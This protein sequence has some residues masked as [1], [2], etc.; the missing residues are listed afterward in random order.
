VATGK[1]KRICIFCGRL[2]LTNEHVIPQWVSKVVARPRPKQSRQ[3]TVFSGPGEGRLL[4][5]KSNSWQSDILGTMAKQVCSTCNSGWMSQLESA[6]Q[7]LVTPML[8]GIATELTPDAQ[9]VLARWAFKTSSMVQYMRSPVVPVPSERL[10]WL[11]K[12]AEPPTKAWVALGKYNGGT[13]ASWC[14]HKGILWRGEG[15]EPK[16]ARGQLVTLS[17]GQLVIQSVAWQGDLDLSVKLSE[18]QRRYLL[19]IWPRTA[20]IILKWP[21]TYGLRD[22]ELV[23]IAQTFAKTD[24]VPASPGL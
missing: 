8:Q 4:P 5:A 2:P 12:E 14:F 20:S 17:L 21:P 7:P 19:Q 18:G 13:F 24:D 1:V 15:T 10:D 23:G 3:Y 16:T 9:E 22:E 6:A 11:R